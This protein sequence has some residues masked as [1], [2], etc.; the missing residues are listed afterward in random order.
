[1]PLYN[2]ILPAPSSINVFPVLLNLLI[3]LI[4]GR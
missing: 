2:I 3:Y 4:F 1:V